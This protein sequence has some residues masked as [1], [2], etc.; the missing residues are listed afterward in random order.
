M[1]VFITKKADLKLPVDPKLSEC[2]K[3][4]SENLEMSPEELNLLC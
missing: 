3:T 2:Q 1:V 4:L